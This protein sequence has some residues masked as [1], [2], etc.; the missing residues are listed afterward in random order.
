MNKTQF[1]NGDQRK[2][3]KPAFK[4]RRIYPGFDK[5]GLLISAEGYTENGVIPIVEKPREWPEYWDRL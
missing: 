5:A 1:Q 2:T 3:W 4:L